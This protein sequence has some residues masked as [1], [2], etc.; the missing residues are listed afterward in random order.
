MVAD[1]REHHDERGEQDEEGGRV[2]Q[3]VAGALDG[4]EETLEA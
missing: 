4:V 1:P 2:R 3:C